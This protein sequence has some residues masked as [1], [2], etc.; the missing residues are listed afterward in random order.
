M[1]DGI[2]TSALEHIHSGV[3]ATRTPSGQRQLNDEELD[4]VAGGGGKVGAST[5]PVE[6]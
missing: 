6:D 3:A 1:T 5:N 4:W 2:T